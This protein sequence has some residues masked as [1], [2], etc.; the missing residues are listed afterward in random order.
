MKRFTEYLMEKVGMKLPSSNIKKSS[1]DLHYSWTTAKGNRVNLFFDP[2]ADGVYD[3]SF[4]VNDRSQED[5]ARSSDREILQ[6]VLYQIKK[7]IDDYNI[8]KFSFEAWSDAM[9]VKNISKLT[10]PYYTKLTQ[11]YK[12][13]EN[14]YSV[15]GSLYTILRNFPE[16]H[17]YDYVLSSIKQT[18]ILLS[19]TDL[20]DQL[21][22][23]L[24]TLKDMFNKILD[25]MDNN[26]S[27][28]DAT[29]RRLII[30]KRFLSQYLGPEWKI[31]PKGKDTIV[32][33]KTN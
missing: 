17:R 30:Y 22:D 7:T 2:D 16:L 11:L 10:K 27:Q 23:F 3:V 15:S 8:T 21:R 18:N 5:V 13:Y 19:Y 25:M 33:T 14:D 32:A 4:T 12:K 28:S 26:S 20:D 24:N 9:D 1:D 31:T 29:N 6:T